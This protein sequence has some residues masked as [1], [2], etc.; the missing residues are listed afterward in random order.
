LAELTPE[1]AQRLSTFRR[2]IG[3][4][5]NSARVLQMSYEAC[6]NGVC[7]EFLHNAGFLG[8]LIVLAALTGTMLVFGIAVILFQEGVRRA[9]HGTKTHLASLRDLSAK[10]Q[11]LQAHRRSVLR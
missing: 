4:F 2:L 7:N 6:S 8:V 1:K 9:V 10:D 3:A 11:W 5:D